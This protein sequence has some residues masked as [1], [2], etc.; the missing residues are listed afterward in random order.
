MNWIDEANK[1]LEKQRANFQESLDSG[2][3]AKRAKSAGGKIGGKTSNSTNAG[4]S[5][6][7]SGQLLA[8]AIKGGK[9]TGRMH[10]ESGHLEKVRDINKAR[11]AS[12]KKVKCI[13]CGKEA[14]T[15]NHARWHGDNCKTL[16]QD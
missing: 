10:V 13:H 8:A 12:L 4:L 1:Q 9:T 7:T 3:A 16:K 14:A 6:K 5:A 15:F 11:A 2:E